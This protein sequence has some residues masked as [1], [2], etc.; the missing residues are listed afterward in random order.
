MDVRCYDPSMSVHQ[1]ECIQSF[2]IFRSFEN[3]EINFFSKI[4]KNRPLVKIFCDLYK[5]FY[6][7]YLHNWN[8]A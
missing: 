5:M 7:F 3:F 2:K 6:N 8:K 4:A 1:N